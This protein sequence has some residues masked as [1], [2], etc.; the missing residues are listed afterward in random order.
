MKKALSVIL[1]LIM[2]MTVFAA[3][4]LEASAG[5]FE[6]LNWGIDKD[7]VEIKYPESHQSSMFI[8]NS[9]YLHFSRPYGTPYNAYKPEFEP[10]EK[11]DIYITWHDNSLL[12]NWSI[13]FNDVP[14]PYNANN[15]VQVGA[16]MEEERFPSGVYDI[17]VYDS[18]THVFDHERYAHIERYIIRRSLFYSVTY[19]S[20]YDQLDAP[21]HLRWEDN[22]AKW[23][24]VPH[25]TRYLITVY[26][27]N[28]DIQF[29]TSTTNTFYQCVPETYWHFEVQ[30][31]DDTGNYIK[32]I[33]AIGSPLRAYS[34]TFN[35]NGGGGTWYGVTTSGKYVLPTTTYFT[36]P[37]DSYKF[38]GWSTTPD[39]K[40]IISSVNLTQNITVYAVWNKYTGSVDTNVYW[41]LED[42]VL[43]IYGDGPIQNRTQGYPNPSPFRNNTE[44]KKVVIG[45]G[46]TQ[47]G[48]WF[49]DG[50]TNIETLDLSNA[51]SLY[52]I[53]NYAFNGCTGLSEIIYPSD[54]GVSITQLGAGAFSGCSNLNGFCLAD[55]DS[56]DI[57]YVAAHAFENCT[58]L[59]SVTIPKSAAGV[60][61]NAF[62][63]C[64][65]LEKI[66]YGGSL[67]DWE[68]LYKGANNDALANATVFPYS[69][70]GEQI[71]DNAYFVADAFGQTGR[72]IGSGDTWNYLGGASPTALKP[73]QEVIVDEGI[74]CIGEC[75]FY[76][77]DVL[78]TVTL[79]STLQTINYSAFEKCDGIESIV[80]PDNTYLISDFAFYE[81]TKLKRVFLGSELEAIN[82]GA[83]S[84]CES[85]EKVY[86]YD[87]KDVFDSKVF[88]DSNNYSFD[89][90][91]F[92]PLSGACGP[93]H[94]YMFEPETGT[95]SIFGSG[96]MDNFTSTS[97][98]WYDYKNDI[99]NVVIHD[100]V[101]AIGE[102]AFWLC[103][104]IETVDFG[105]TLQKIGKYAFSGCNSLTGIVLPETLTTIGVQAFADC[106][107][108]KTI[109]IPGKVTAIPNSTFNGCTS[110]ESIF[111]P[112]SVK[113]IG[114]YS[115]YN[116]PSLT[117][118]YYGGTEQELNKITI[119][120][121][122]S[123]LETVTVNLNTSMIAGWQLIDGKWYYYNTNGEKQTGWVK[124]GGKWYYMNSD[125]VMQTGWQKV[126]GK[127]YYM[128]K[129]GVM[130]TGWVKVSG[131]WYYMN[132]SG[133]MQT[134]WQKI[135]GKWY[136]LN[137]SGVMQTGWQK[138]G[139]KWYY[140]NSSGVM[141]TGWQKI[142]GKWY[143]FET[144]G[145][146]LSNTSKT[147]NGKKYNFNSS[148]VC[149][150][151]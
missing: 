79:P 90:A 49:F 140:L 81:C 24:A 143:Y 144:S 119:G 12:G 29:N 26:N 117:D 150:N 74:T 133:V 77:C 35:K 64:D 59:K 134:G 101:T 17:T 7:V 62:D 87:S 40:N 115:F 9:G 53:G 138:I 47:I 76:D 71:G 108:V 89:D 33:R 141:Q 97:M 130:Q 65:S 70:W 44:I 15:T 21:T 78:N 19:L 127:W 142:D 38:V 37:D 120:D 22:M 111:I 31:C 68:N 20:P 25:A 93:C 148:G 3:L 14:C 11:V 46:I 73:V 55:I 16:K 128:N 94:A 2:V 67:E 126:G 91:T 5:M 99:K 85:L 69:C 147:I 13:A 8:D 132:S 1:S 23:E 103:S 27:K 18:E 105:N 98:P 96:E 32:S 102:N 63:G 110:L 135:G 4:P 28:N 104:N 137:S 149:T 118:I 86:Y 42:G 100:G 75:L 109:I 61:E 88:V 106:E 151:P 112:R 113:S 83:F 125:G 41:N 122:N 66:F 92:I 95:L 136:Y 123:Q 58:S 139:G 80:I 84:S 52:R 131:K 116:C 56:S 54:L 114:N 57:Q 124:V 145:V 6:F 34:V 82:Y 30:A 60:A 36:P 107:L 72:I 48:D 121:G 50:C 10:T 146:M 43:N 51:N 39:G 45:S 129:S